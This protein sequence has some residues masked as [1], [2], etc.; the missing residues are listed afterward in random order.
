MQKYK[1]FIGTIVFAIFTLL[2]AFSFEFIGYGN[3]AEPPSILII[4]P[5]ATDEM[6]IKLN[7][8]DG[9]HE[10]RVTDKVIEK[11]YAFYSSAMFKN[12]N[13][14]SFIVSTGEDSFEVEL[15]KPIKNYNN[16]YTLDLKSHTLTE[17]KLLS[18]SVMLVSMR[19]VLTLVIEAAVFWSFG[20]RDKK[21]WKVFLIINF[22]TQGAL[23]IWI[24][25]FT[26]I[27]SYVIFTL[28]FGEF[29]VFIAE[30]FAFSLFCREHGRLRKILYVSVANFASLI[31]GGYII[32]V[33][34]I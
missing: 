17:G 6:S 5:N 14:Y 4:V 9:E 32:T 20:F 22:V 24:N 15:D 16:V 7:L 2:F 29:F 18:R 11:Y 30:L 27:T 10:A 19:I 26:P 1:K 25:S 33:L 28:I 21:S 3:S 23:N 12:T 13:V 31:L 8:E 34:P